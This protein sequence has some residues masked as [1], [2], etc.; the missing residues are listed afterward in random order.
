MEFKHTLE[1]LYNQAEEIASMANKFQS[2]QEIRKIEI[3]L[4]LEKLRNIY[5]LASDVRATLHFREDPASETGQPVQHEV[6]AA[7]E[8]QRDPEPVFEVED[9]PVREEIIEEISEEPVRETRKAE[10]EP[11]VHRDIPKAQ[12]SSATRRTLNEEIHERTQRE[13]VASQYKLTP[14]ASITSAMG[15]N[16][17]FELINELF[18]G[19]RLLFDETMDILNRSESFVDASNYLEQHFDWNL[20]NTYVQRLLELIRR[21]LITRRNEQ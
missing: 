6:V 2:G 12:P 20:E 10:P 13:D 19:D 8:P 14:I 4:L 1:I 9:E 5:D 11:Y 21:K 3:D 16:E 7:P 18:G 15:I 17:R